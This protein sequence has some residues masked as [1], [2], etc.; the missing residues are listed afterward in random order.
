[1]AQDHARP[2]RV[3]CQPQEA[4]LAEARLAN[5]EEIDIAE[6]STLASTL[7]R[8]AQRIGIDRRAKNITPPLRDYIEAKATGGAP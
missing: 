4:K 8:I 3:G 1:M 2:V 5:G 7:V 6:H